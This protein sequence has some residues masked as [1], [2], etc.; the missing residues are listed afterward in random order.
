MEQNQTSGKSGSS[1]EP[2]AGPGTLEAHSS[3]KRT[4]DLGRAK[5][6]WRAMFTS[7]ARLKHLRRMRAKNL[8]HNCD[9]AMAKGIEHRARIKDNPRM[10]RYQR[11]LITLG[12]DVK[13]N[14][15]VNNLKQEKEIMA[16]ERR[17]LATSMG[18][19]P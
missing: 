4:H 15:E 17:A 13:I 7:K 2:T 10:R 1:S 18:K 19:H 12:M 6:A 11:D 5:K 9:E 16:T 14:D 3:V 8:G